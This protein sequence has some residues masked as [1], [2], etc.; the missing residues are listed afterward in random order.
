MRIDMASR[1]VYYSW[2][3]HTEKVA[4]ALAKLLGAE[5]VRIEPDRECRIGREAMKA[6][7]GMK[8]PIRP[9]KNDLSGIDALIIASPVWAGKVPPYVN[10]YLD[11]VRGGTGKP[12]HVIVEMGGRGDQSAIARVRKA[13]ER[14]GMKFVSSA[15]TI[16]KDVE[17]G[18][19]AGTLE[20][21]AAG[22]RKQ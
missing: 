16:E 13:L 12:F 20:Q 10:A 7:L 14:K 8:S 4:T 22:I 2:K 11:S 6:F 3:G 21:F 17:S 18:A 1:V 5:L 15:S 9:T 19:F